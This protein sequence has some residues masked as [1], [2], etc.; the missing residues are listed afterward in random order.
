MIAWPIE[1]AATGAPRAPRRFGECLRAALRGITDVASMLQARA[2][3][4]RPAKIG[5]E[6]LQ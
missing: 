5:G 2:G 6:V 1:A 4:V 3:A